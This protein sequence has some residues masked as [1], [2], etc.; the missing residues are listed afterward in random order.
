MPI[1]PNALERLLFFGLNVGPGPVLDIFGA[2]A[3]RTVLAAVNLGVFDVLRDGSLTAADLAH[4]IGADERGVTVLLETLIPLGYVTKKGQRYANTAMARKWLVRSSPSTI[5]AGY[6]F[7]GTTLRELWANLED[8]IRTGQPPTH[9]YDWI[10]TQPATSRAFQQWM[11]AIAHLNADEIIGKLKLPPTARR[12]LDIGGG[13]AMY[14]IALCQRYPQMTTTVIDSPEALTV[15][16][17]TVAAA[18]MSDRITLHAGDF[19]HDDF[20]KAYD[21][22]LLFNI[23]HGL[24]ASQNCVLVQKVAD[25]LV[26]GGQIVIVE[27]LADKAPGPTT[28]AVGQLLGLSYFHLLGGQIY[29]FDEVADWLRAAGFTQPQRKNLLKSSSGSL[30]LAAKGGAAT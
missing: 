2:V 20:G 6:E 23:V 27:Q 21:V 29:T 13:H 22:A 12:M 1:V 7:W 4:R 24:D 10:E 11:V 5:A 3:F 9:L 28:R 17:E 19:L 15:A 26:A 8:S 25:A 30:I 16:H 14:S 18:K